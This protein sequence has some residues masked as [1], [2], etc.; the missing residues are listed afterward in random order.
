M[1]N[2]VIGMCLM[3]CGLSVAQADGGA[4]YRVTITNGALHQVITPSLIITHRNHFQLFKIG[5]PASDSL[6][7]LGRDGQ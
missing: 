2:I 7:T 4:T 1:K 3:L 5:Q 6:A